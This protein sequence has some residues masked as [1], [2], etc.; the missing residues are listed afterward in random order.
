MKL[1][2]ILLISLV[3]VGC[4]GGDETPVAVIKTSVP[5]PVANAATVSG[6]SGVGVNE[7]LKRAMV[8]HDIDAKQSAHDDY[9]HLDALTIPNLQTAINRLNFEGV[10]F[11]A[12]KI[13]ADSFLTDIAKRI[14]QQ[15][16][17]NSNKN[18]NKEILVCILRCSQKF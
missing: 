7:G 4:G 1:L 12:L 11:S 3:L 16:T 13:P 2:S 9:T 18:Q 8:G 10:D 6:G 5:H 14:K 17:R 15:N